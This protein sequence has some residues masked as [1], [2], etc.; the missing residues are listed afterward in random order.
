MF[1]RLY[2]FERDTW[3]DTGMHAGR[4]LLAAIFSIALG[5]AI[6]LI[7]T[8]LQVLIGAGL[9][10]IGANLLMLAIAG[11]AARRQRRTRGMARPEWWLPWSW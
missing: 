3:W 6:A 2:F 10:L 7:P 4:L 9:L 1:P 11:F 8:F 5:M